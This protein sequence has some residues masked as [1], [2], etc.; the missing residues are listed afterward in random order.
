MSGSFAKGA[1]RLA[2]LVPRL[3]GWTPAA[4]WQATP[5]ELAAV[6]SPEGP[7]EA[8][9]LARSELERMMEQDG[10]G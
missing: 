4:F 2:G 8:A 10:H 3:L 6:L 9:P 5:S 7:G 1:A